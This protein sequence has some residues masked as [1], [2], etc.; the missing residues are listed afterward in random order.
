MKLT[1]VLLAILVLSISA[2]TNGSE[3]SN[4]ETSL[5]NGEVIQTVYERMDVAEFQTKLSTV[6]DP[7]LIDVRTPEE[8]AQGNIPGSV[9]YN[10][11]GVDFMQK[12]SQLDKNKPVFVYCQAGGRSK[13]SAKKM[14]SLGFKEI[15]E[16]APGY[17]QWEQ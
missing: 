7:Q 4:N 17:S 11:K 12:I 6:S 1:P 9:N 13:K 8:Y 16:L 2:C 5:P 3:S 14:K 15:Y 10:I